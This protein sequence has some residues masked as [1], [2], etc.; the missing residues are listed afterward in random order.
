MLKPLSLAGALLGVFCGSTAV[1]QSLEDS[2]VFALDA[3]PLLE[4]E[5][6]AA[7]AAYAGI[8]IARAPTRPS[9]SIDSSYQRQDVQRTSAFDQIA[10]TQS[11]SN[12][13]LDTL[14]VSLNV[15]QSLYEGYRNRA[16]IA[17]ATSS[18]AAADANVGS[19]RQ[20]LILN[21]VSAH[22]DVLRDEAVLAFQ[23]AS[24]AALEEQVRGAKR[25]F[26]LRDATITD[27]AQAE[28]R[29]ANADAR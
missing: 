13:D 18:A 3:N 14:D 8:D 2:I 26:E 5:R 11:T 22:A 10:G 28:A 25:R 20:S 21:A 27:V 6:A 23:Q 4:A 7:R 9:V 1:A 16:R 17:E 24:V 15:T 12:L 29:R 19:V